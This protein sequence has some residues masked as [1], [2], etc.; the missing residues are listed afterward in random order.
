MPLPGSSSNFTQ[1]SRAYSGDGVQRGRP[2]SQPSFLA[3]EERHYQNISIYQQQN[4]LQSPQSQQL[5]NGPPSPHSQGLQNVSSP[6]KLTNFQHHDDRLSHRMR[7]SHGSLNRPDVQQ[8]P[9]SLPQ[10]PVSALLSQWEKEHISGPHQPPHPGPTHSSWSRT[11]E[12]RVSQ[13][14]SPHRGVEHSNRIHSRPPV[15]G[16]GE[17]YLLKI[18]SKHFKY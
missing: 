9:N 13:Q 14:H 18:S 12:E 1:Q 10:R 11:N 6:S 2:L 5:L 8:Q 7:G 15:D 3:E 16:H 17:E 4:H